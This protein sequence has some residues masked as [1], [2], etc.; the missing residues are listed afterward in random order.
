MSK[1]SRRLFLSFGL[2]ILPL[3]L[4]A[5]TH[6]L[7]YNP[8]A[9]ASE[10]LNNTNVG[11]CG[12]AAV[13][14][15]ESHM[16]LK[17]SIATTAVPSKNSQIRNCPSTSL[18]VNGAYSYWISDVPCIKS[19]LQADGYTVT[20]RSTTNRNSAV[21]AIFNSLATKHW[22][23]ILA[24]HGFNLTEMGHFYPVFGGNKTSSAS[25]S[26][27]NAIEDFYQTYDPQHP[28]WSL[29]YRNGVNLNTILDSMAS[30]ST[31]NPKTYNI[32][33]VY[34]TTPPS[35]TI[36]SP[37]SG[38]TFSTG[39]SYTLSWSAQDPS[40]VGDVSVE[41]ISGSATSCINASTISYI[42]QAGLGYVASTSWRVPTSLTRGS[43]KL[44]VAVRDNLNNWGCVMMPVSV[45]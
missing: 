18:S 11:S 9:Y 21:D 16:Q 1:Q 30:A 31:T 41:L 44:K 8:Y 43:Y 22:V 40:G 5:D 36:T 12:A 23:I 3:S 20:N 33:E 25:T 29:M 28:N 6:W 38:F 17:S 42:R 37:Q 45:R 34:E 7:T 26:T 39:S 2:F 35:I 14:L 27:L 13:V 24:R 19:V 15:V 4:W 32:L 10:F